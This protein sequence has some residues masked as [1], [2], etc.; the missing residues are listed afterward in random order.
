MFPWLSVTLTFAVKLLLLPNVLYEHVNRHGEGT[1]VALPETMFVQ[2]SRAAVPVL[3]LKLGDV[4]VIGLSEAVSVVAPALKSVM[5]AV[6]PT[7]FA[8]VTDAG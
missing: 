1:G 3:T 4:P 2:A 6:V 5:F 8:N 7:P